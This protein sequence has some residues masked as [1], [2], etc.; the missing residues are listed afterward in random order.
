MNPADLILTHM[1]DVLSL[2]SLHGDSL[3]MFLNHVMANALEQSSAQN[4]RMYFAYQ[5]INTLVYTCLSDRDLSRDHMLAA[6]N[7]LHR[8]SQDLSKVW[9]AK[10]G[11]ALPIYLSKYQYSKILQNCRDPLEVIRLIH[12]TLDIDPLPL[13]SLS[14]I[15]SH[16]GLDRMFEDLFPGVISNVMCR[17]NVGHVSASLFF[18]APHEVLNLAFSIDSGNLKADVLKMFLMQP[19]RAAKVPTGDPWTMWTSS[20]KDYIATGILHA[21]VHGST[22][23]TSVCK[24]LSLF[25]EVDWE[26]CASRQPTRVQDASCTLDLQDHSTWLAHYTNTYGRL[27]STAKL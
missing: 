1:H 23:E 14:T 5:C 6:I 18:K 16:R 8:T 2:A 26:Y 15:I 12:V 27:L 9:E 7:Y 24:M 19:S 20:I 22:E 13:A 3:Q 4:N 25:Q 11:H 10:F 17:V 21:F